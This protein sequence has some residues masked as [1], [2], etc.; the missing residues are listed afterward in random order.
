MHSFR[1]YGR[2]K[3]DREASAAV[4]YISAAPPANGA[5]SGALI[6]HAAAVHSRSQRGGLP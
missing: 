2:S 5:D 4:E 6:R 3:G 1:D